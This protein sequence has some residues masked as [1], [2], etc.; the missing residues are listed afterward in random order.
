[1]LNKKLITFSLIMLFC[2]SVFIP[3]TYAEPNT[4]DIPKSGQTESYNPQDD[5]IIQA[6]QKWP[7]NRFAEEDGTIKDNLTGLRWLKD[8]NCVAGD[9][10]G[11]KYLDV[12]DQVS[13]FNHDPG[14]LNCDSYNVA[15]HTQGWRLPTIVE[16]LS[17]MHVA[18]V[19]IK[20]DNSTSYNC[21]DWLESQGFTDIINE[22]WSSTI[23]AKDND[24]VWYVHTYSALTN[25]SKINDFGNPG[26]Y[27]VLLVKE[28]NL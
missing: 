8:G 26:F 5:G 22:Y 17:L 28:D 10:G 24:Y 25:T 2:L 19:T 7:D 16:F 23:D 14:S 27:H 3:Y 18:P 20:P 11:V 13:Q 9:P 1:M 21:G 6:G 15:T 4:T 12:A